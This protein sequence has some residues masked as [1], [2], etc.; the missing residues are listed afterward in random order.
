MFVEYTEGVGSPGFGFF[1]PGGM[2]VWRSQQRLP[3][4]NLAI[5]KI[6]L[7]RP[8]VF[9]MQGASESGTSG[10]ISRD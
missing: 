6:K 1:R 8:A 5:R 7:L 3:T 9:S 10:P 2:G 4:K